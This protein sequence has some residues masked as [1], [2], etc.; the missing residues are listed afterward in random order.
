MLTALG[1]FME[2]V[3][4][5]AKYCMMYDFQWIFIKIRK[6]GGLVERDGVP[7]PVEYMFICIWRNYY[8]I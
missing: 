7:R 8:Y 4:P 6:I 3:Q 2:Y 5:W 1:Y